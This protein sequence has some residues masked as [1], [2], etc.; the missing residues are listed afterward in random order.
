[1]EEVRNR[2][3][4]REPPPCNWKETDTKLKVGFGGGKKV[5]GKIEGW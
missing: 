4:V 5:A 2:G 3:Y 1:M